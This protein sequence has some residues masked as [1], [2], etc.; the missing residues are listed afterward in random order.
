[1][2]IFLILLIVFVISLIIYYKSKRDKARAAE[3]KKQIE[4]EHEESEK[5]MRPKRK[6]HEEE[7]KRWE[8]EYWKR[9]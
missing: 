2:G 9:H 4:I 5:I 6:L 3:I 7:K 8:N 1:M